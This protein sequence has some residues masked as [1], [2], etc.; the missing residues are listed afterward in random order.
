MKKKPADPDDS[1]ENQTERSPQGNAITK[2]FRVHSL[3]LSSKDFRVISSTP[4]IT[5]ICDKELKISV[6]W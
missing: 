1:S 3:N 5:A 6:R 2:R 4:L